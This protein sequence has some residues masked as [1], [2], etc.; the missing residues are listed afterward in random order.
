LSERGRVDLW[1]FRSRRGGEKQATECLWDLGNAR[2]AR[3]GEKGELP[4]HSTPEKGER[5]HVLIKK[6]DQYP[7]GRRKE[8]KEKGYLTNRKI[9]SKKRKSQ[10]YCSSPERKR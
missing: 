2:R 4:I 10:V 7:G 9:R 8:E 3:G 6:N 5:R 1:G